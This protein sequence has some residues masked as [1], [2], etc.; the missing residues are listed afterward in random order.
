MLMPALTSAGDVEH[1]HASH[2][3]GRYR[4]EIMM[5]IDSPVA[6]VRELMQDLERLHELSDAISESPLLGPAGV[7]PARRR[8]VTETCIWFFCFG[9]IYEER[10]TQYSPDH[11]EARIDPAHSDY[12]Y[13]LSVWRTESLDRRRTRIE[14][15]CDIEP[16]FWVPPIIGPWMIKQ[17][18]RQETEATINNIERLT[19]A[20]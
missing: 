9:S 14:F 5:V 10:I 1:V 11:F 17:K 6:A 12:H 7:T 15:I 13:G 8:V 4:L 2:A 16:A 19:R 18:M 3:D 20:D